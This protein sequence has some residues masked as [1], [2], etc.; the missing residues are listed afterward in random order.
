LLERSLITVH[1]Q[2]CPL[3]QTASFVFLSSL[4]S[5]LF[6]SIHN[7]FKNDLLFDEAVNVND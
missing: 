2:V 4:P 3:F 1:L 5:S 6:K 7:D